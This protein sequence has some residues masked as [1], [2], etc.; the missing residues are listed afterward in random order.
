MDDAKLK[1][2]RTTRAA[3]TTQLTWLGLSSI[4]LIAP[5]I[6]AVLVLLSRG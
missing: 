2:S 1:A 3:A 5:M 6:P 4:A